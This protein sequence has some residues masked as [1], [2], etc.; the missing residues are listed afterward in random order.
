MRKT[1]SPSPTRQ[2]IHGL[3]GPKPDKLKTSLQSQSRGE[4]GISAG[5]SMNLEGTG[6]L[7]I[8]FCASAN[9][10]MYHKS[11][12]IDT[13]CTSQICGRFYASTE[14]TNGT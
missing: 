12:L 1:R 3:V 8:S 14:G 4:S 5:K 9:I 11:F 2:G 7:W 10:I 13:Y 6:G